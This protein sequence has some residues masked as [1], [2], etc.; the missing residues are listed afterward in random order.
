PKSEAY[1][2]S[3]AVIDAKTGRLLF[4][5]NAHQ[6]APIASLTKIWTAY[7]TTE[8][9]NIQDEA[10][11]STNAA[12][13]EGS[14]IFLKAGDNQQI[15]KLLYG[16]ML[17]SG[18]DSAVAIAEHVGGSVE[19]FVDLMNEKA[20]VAGLQHT[21]FRNPSGLHHDE[22]L[23][24]A[25]DTALMLKN[26]MGNKQLKKIMSTDYYRK[27]GVHWENKHKLVR[28]NSLAISG[29]TGYTKAAGRTLATFF[30][31]GK[32]EIIVVTLNDSNDWKSHQQLADRAFKEYS[33][34]QLVQEGAYNLPGD[35][36]VRLNKPIQL[37]VNDKEQVQHV[38]LLNRSRNGVRTGQWTVQ[39][40]GKSVYSQ[41]VHIERNRR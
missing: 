24:T 32:Q 33:M 16:L 37:I 1:G 11:I 41:Q 31:K 10:H 30:K 40:D 39:I 26:A 38:V 27:D 28:S 8:E 19:G 14:S 34:V 5:S 6:Q 15:E 7:V 25:Y 29:K 2:S 21:V 9:V 4:G 12:T 3:Y 23:S 18:N 22:H 17:R 36:V 13:Q 20:R 35:L